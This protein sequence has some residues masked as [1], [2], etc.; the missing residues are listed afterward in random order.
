MLLDDKR[1]FLRSS[2]VD[3]IPH[4]PARLKVQQPQGLKDSKTKE[5]ATTCNP[6]WHRRTCAY[7][8]PNGAPTM[9]RTRRLRILN[10]CLIFFSI[11]IA[12]FAIG[13]AVRVSRDWAAD[14]LK[15]VHDGRFRIALTQQDTVE[16]SYR[17]DGEYATLQYD[18][19]K[20]AFTT[21]PL[22]ADLTG[23]AIK[24]FSDNDME[25]YKFGVGLPIAVTASDVLYSWKSFRTDR[26]QGLRALR[27]ATRNR[28]VLY[29]V[30]TFGGFFAGDYVGGLLKTGCYKSTNLSW[31]DSI[32]WKQIIKN[33]YMLTLLEYQKCID[34][35]SAFVLKKARNAV[36]VRP[37]DIVF[38]ILSSD[39][40]SP[41][42]AAHVEKQKNV[43]IQIADIDGELS[44]D[45]IRQSVK[46]LNECSSIDP[47]TTYSDQKI[48]TA[49]NAISSLVTMPNQAPYRIPKLGR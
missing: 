38:Q 26:L 7:S 47:P 22:P 31:L 32:K 14:P 17:C 39:G 44:I 19:A 37:E 11:T 15:D 5:K 43:D 16:V 33:A 49:L 36:F 45:E 48:E 13:V 18:I 9:T 35:Q 34:A 30:A 27:A 10:F 1:P 24:W 20:K 3:R 42:I 28:V 25:L 29:G 8:P 4:N 41:V 6:E 23:D 2:I 21:H 12:L 46:L 40:K